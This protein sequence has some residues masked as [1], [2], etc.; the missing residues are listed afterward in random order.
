MEGICEELTV[1]YEST[2]DAGISCSIGS[3]DVAVTISFYL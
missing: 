3:P 1:L 2:M